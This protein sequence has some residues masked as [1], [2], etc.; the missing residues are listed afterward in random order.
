MPRIEPIEIRLGKRRLHRLSWAMVICTFLL[1][2]SR[3]P[4]LAQPAINC[5]AELDA[6]VTL[7]TNADYDA[8][9]LQ[10]RFANLETDCSHFA[11][12]A[13]NQGVLAARS[14]QWPQAIAHFERALEKDT[15]AADTHQ[16]L[17]QIF[18]YRAAQAYALALNTP[19]QASAPQLQFQDSGKHNADLQQAQT[20]FH[21]LRN[22]ATIEYELYAWWQAHQ[23]WKGIREHYIND[24]NIEAIKLSR[25]HY[26][27]KQW[28][29][30]KREIAF[31]ANDAVIVLSDSI[32]AHTL[33][34]MRLVGSRW[35]IY[36]ETRL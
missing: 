5:A 17:K 11:Q 28:P 33:L 7:V 20:P 16:H 34:L 10:M 25:Q 12:L 9:A 32:Q 6:A 24:Y 8:A 18:E 27:S 30:T 19:L 23:N 14:N 15:R 22:I 13:H 36:Q 35:K 21:E 3:T 1:I 26:L 4:T 2:S 31:T 29:D